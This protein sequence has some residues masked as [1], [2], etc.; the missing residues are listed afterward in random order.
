MPPG[1]APVSC[2]DDIRVV[3]FSIEIAGP[4]ATKLFADAGADVIKVEPPQGDPF[5]RR[6]VHGEQLDERDA[7]LFRYLHGGKRAVVGTPDDVDVAALIGGADLVVE[8]GSPMLD[9][10]G[11]LERF[12]HLVVLTLSP[13]GRTGPLADRAATAFTVE[14]ESGTLATHGRKDGVPYQTGGRLFDWAH[15][16][17]AAVGALGAVMRATRT[18]SGEHVEATLLAATTFAGTAFHFYGLNEQQGEP[19]LTRPA[20]FVEIPSIE[21]T[22][23]GWVGFMT[24]TH[25][26]FKDFVTMIG[27]PEILEHEDWL[28]QDYRLEHLEE[29]NEFVRP[30]T[31]E[32]TTA[33]VIELASLLRL[34]TAPVSTGE[35]VAEHEQFVARG[36]FAPSPDADLVQPQ[37]PALIDGVRAAITSPAPALG[38][39]TGTIEAREGRFPAQAGRPREELPFQGLRVIDATAFWA[40]PTVGYVF[41]CLGAEVIHIEAIQRP[42]GMRL[43]VSPSQHAL[44]DWWEREYLMLATNGNKRDLTLDLSRP[45]GR[46]LLEALI[47]QSDVLIENFSPRVFEGLGLTR[48]RVLQ[49][50]PAIVFG[51]MPA[52]GLDGPW[53][54]NV[55]FAQTMEQITGIAWRTGHP[56]D[57]PRIPRGPGDPMGGYHACFA[58]MTALHRRAKTGQGAFVESAFVESILNCTAEAPLQY[59][60]YGQLLERQGNRSAEAAPQ[61]IYGCAGWEQWLALSVTSDE[62]WVALKQ[63]LSNPAWAEAPDLDTHAGRSRAHDLIDRELERWCAGRDVEKIVELLATAGIPAAA[64]VDPRVSGKRPQMT[65]LEFYE[66]VDHPVVGMHSVPGMP[67]RY[68]SVPRW[69]KSAAPLLGAHNKDIL[70]SILGLTEADVDRLIADEIIGARPVGS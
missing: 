32:R 30:W 65:A 68:A 50:N 62:Q 31:S 1:A 53:R 13:F 35:T 12:P 59:S 21:P 7:A 57:Q 26:Q 23:D 6:A 48:E 4:Y 5:R 3:D 66:T 15:G 54:D 16:V 47:A 51:R 34:P 28:V 39:H 56:D 41:G 11:L 18:G 49:I 60:S 42:D 19:R 44:P 52:F 64:A 58:V 70:T 2:L 33:E 38:E 43:A 55:G 36:I 46:E 27:H 17:F 8:S 29:W 61:G 37:P 67:F 10:Q 9:V 22:V 25:Q 45:K 69:R 63:V 20:R 40:G 24:G 14:A